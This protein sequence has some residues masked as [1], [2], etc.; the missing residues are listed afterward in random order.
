MSDRHAARPHLVVDNSSRIAFRLRNRRK[1][2]KGDFGMPSLCAS[3]DQSFP[4]AG[5]DAVPRPHGA[6][7]TVCGPDIVGKGP[8]RGPSVDHLLKSLHD[9]AT[10]QNVSAVVNT[11]RSDF[12]NT[13]CSVIDPERAKRL[14]SYRK[15][16]GYEHASDFARR[17]RGL[18][19]GTHRS[20]ENA[21]RGIPRD[22]AKDYEQFFK[23][24]KATQ[25]VTADL[26]LWGPAGKPVADELIDDSVRVQ[27]DTLL[28]PLTEDELERA[29]PSISET[30][31]LVKK[32]G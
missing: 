25:H 26:L 22:A 1:K 5:R 19:V 14:R 12:I 17:H 32:A 3:L 11:K 27:I 28:D 15:L 31:R 9:A 23:H 13:M 2:F 16:A 18:E 6:G 10:V 29:L 7:M 30:I 21:T 4:E 20:R 24:Y 8:R